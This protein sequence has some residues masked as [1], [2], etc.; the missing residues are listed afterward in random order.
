MELIS[1]TTHQKI[2]TI[3]WT[4]AFFAVTVSGTL[5]GAGLRGREQIKKRERESHDS[6]I[7]DQINMLENRRTEMMVKKMALER[8]L[9][10]VEMRR[11][12]ASREESVSTQGRSWR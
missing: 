4:G 8:K 3:V 2:K 12:G 5:Y 9:E 7:A 11:N 6:S 1:R 10:Q